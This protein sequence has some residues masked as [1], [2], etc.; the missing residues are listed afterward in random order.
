MNSVATLLDPNLHRH[1]KLT[2]ANHLQQFSRDHVLPVDAE[3]Y[4][5]LACEYPLV[6]VKNSE[7]GQFTA[8]AL[9]GLVSGSNLYYQAGQWQA[10]TLPRTVQ[11]YPLTFQMAAGQLQLAVQ[12]SETALDR[13]HGIPLYA[14]DGAESAELSQRRAQ[15]IRHLQQLHLLREW[16]GRLEALDLL[17]AQVLQLQD[18]QQI[19][20]LYLVN[21][22]RLKQL[23]AEQLKQCH[24]GNDM[25]LIMAH[26]LSLQHLSR[27]VLWAQQR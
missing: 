11:N 26:I 14:A 3:E 22:Q 7:T 18:G 15:L 12:D 9:T 10:A 8:V 6:F 1:L 21:Q 19:N 17:Q 24:Q 4:L 27:L 23:S 2:S 20:G 16:V 5:Q 13:Q 25:L